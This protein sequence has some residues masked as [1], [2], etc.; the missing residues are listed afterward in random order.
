MAHFLSNLHVDYIYGQDKYCKHFAKMLLIY[1]LKKKAL[2][3]A[4]KKELNT[5]QEK[6]TNHPVVRSTASE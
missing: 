3:H 5:H 4:V 6:V 2:S 1:F